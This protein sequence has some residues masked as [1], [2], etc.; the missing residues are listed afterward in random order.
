MTTTT[1]TL[2]RRVRPQP[3]H[4]LLL[5]FPVAFSVG[6]VLADAAYLASAEI[7]WSTFS[8]W[9]IAFTAM[10]AGLVLLRGL[11]DLIFARRDGRFGRAGL[12]GLTIAAVLALSVVNSF[13]HAR[14]GWL[15][16]GPLGMTLSIVTAL[17]ALLAGLML[18]SGWTVRG[19]AR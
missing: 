12:Y 15:S 10:F 3:V 2:D 1:P 13:Q 4:G 9:L 7:Q 5:A 8:T 19:I 14:D 17:L 6:A 16:V 18:Y 11:I